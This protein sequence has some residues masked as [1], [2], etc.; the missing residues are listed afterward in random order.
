MDNKLKG[1]LRITQKA[2]FKKETVNLL[3]NEISMVL[4]KPPD[5]F[6]LGFIVIKSKWRIWTPIWSSEKYFFRTYR[7][8]YQTECSEIEISV[9]LRLFC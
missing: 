5:G 2:Y 1:L 3:I 6:R 8:R 9:N 7:V 4:S